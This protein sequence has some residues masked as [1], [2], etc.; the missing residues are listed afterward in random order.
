MQSATSF[1]L[2]KVPHHNES[3]N[4]SRCLDAIYKTYDA[5]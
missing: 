1:I 3:Y 2:Y 5:V 4:V